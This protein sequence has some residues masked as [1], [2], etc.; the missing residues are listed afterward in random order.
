VLVGEERL[1]ER[2][3]D[4]VGAEPGGD[5][6]E[7]GAVGVVEVVARGEEL[8]GFGAALMESIEQ[9]GMQAL[10]KEDVGRE[11]GLH[12]LLRYSSGRI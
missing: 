4:V 10:L 2:G 3:G 5:V 6:A 12:H 7:D 8:D 1:V 11:A 9:A